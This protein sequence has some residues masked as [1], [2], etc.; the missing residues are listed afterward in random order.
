MSEVPESAAPVE[1]APPQTK[2]I[3]KEEEESNP[4]SPTRL[5]GAA[6]VGAFGGL[7]AYYFYCNVEP[8]TRK[9]I[10]G[11]AVSLVKGQV[12]NWMESDEEE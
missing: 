7:L 6:V 2:K 8:S 1:E 9:R 5:F 11:R 10:R 4:Y 12:R 3:R